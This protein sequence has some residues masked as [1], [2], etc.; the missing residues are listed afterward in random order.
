MSAR[1]PAMRT[2][3][4]RACAALLALALLILAVE[5]AGRASRPGALREAADP[6]LWG[7][8][9]SALQALD[10]AGDAA[11]ETVE[12]PPSFEEEVLS[13]KGRA[14]ARVDEQGDVAGFSV[15]ASADDAFTAVS[16]EL[17]AKGWTRVDSGAA[18][19]GTFVKERGAYRWAFASCVQA[20]AATCVVVQV[21]P[22]KQEGA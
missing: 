18:A 4:L 2:R 3:A 12:A 14:D 1:M 17:E 11:A 21:A 5:A 9:G 16:F 7:G 10:D 13:L 22:A 8:A 6:L 20:G 15:K 19:C